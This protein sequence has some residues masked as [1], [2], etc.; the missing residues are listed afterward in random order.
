MKEET[1]EL[2]EWIK[3]QIAEEDKELRVKA[4]QFLDSLPEIESHLCR[5]GYVQDRNGILCC[6]GDII[7][8]D[9]LDEEIGV[10]YWSKEDSRFY[11]KNN[12]HLCSLGKNFIKVMEK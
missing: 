2:V 1:K 3:E 10:L 8:K 5:G 11:F 7:I 12:R 4:I 6:D 9:I